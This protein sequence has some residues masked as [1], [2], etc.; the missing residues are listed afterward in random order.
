M[1]RAYGLLHPT[2]DFT[3]QEAAARL[4]ARLPGHSVILAGQLTVSSAGWEIALRLDAEP[5]VRQE[6]VGFAQK[7][8]GWEDP[9]YLE[10]CDRRVEV[11]SDTPD[12]MMEHFND[13][14]T[15]VEVLKSF[16][17]LVAVD[18]K[19]AGLI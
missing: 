17:G 5:Y 11:W 8:A 12:P 3:L 19:D 15:V 9:A 13:Y 1:Y 16:S 2:S 18:P 7:I 4:R 10:A 14:L 6:S